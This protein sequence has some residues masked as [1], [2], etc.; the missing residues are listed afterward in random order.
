MRSTLELPDSLVAE[1]R[2]L[3]GLATKREVVVAALAEFVRR[4]K[5]ALL[6]SQL[7]KGDYDLTQDELERMRA[8]E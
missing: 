5:I 6:R 3:S 2:D 8:D 7:G 1:A 4:R